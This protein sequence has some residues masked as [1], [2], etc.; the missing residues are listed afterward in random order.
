VGG[1]RYRYT[2]RK[3]TVLNCSTIVGH[4]GGPCVNQAGQVI[5][6]LSCADF[7]QR[8]RSYLVPTSEF[9]HL[10]PPKGA[11]SNST[12]LGC[13]AA[14]GDNFQDRAPDDDGENAV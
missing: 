8:S 6:I 14:I 12:I 10:I 13:K 5:G 7:T 9:L 2:P 1:E 3:K 4:S 11:I